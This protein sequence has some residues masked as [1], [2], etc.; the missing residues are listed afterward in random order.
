[1][2]WLGSAS[3]LD[4]IELI[5]RVHLDISDIIVVMNTDMMNELER[6]QALK[7]KDQLLQ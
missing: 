3:N 2:I 6:N 1:M 4:L 7:T 5:A